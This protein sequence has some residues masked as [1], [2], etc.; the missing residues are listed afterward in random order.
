[1]SERRRRSRWWIL[2]GIAV[3]VLLLVAF[4]IALSTREVAPPSVDDALARLGRDT[5]PGSTVAGPAR[6]QPGLYTASG[7]GTEK[8]SL[9]PNAQRQ[10]PVLPV[11]VSADGEA[12]RVVRIDYTAN[13]WQ[14]WRYCTGP[15]ATVV[16]TGGQVFQ[17]IDLVVLT[18]ESTS[19]FVCDPP[20]VILRADA[21]PGDVVD[22]RCTGTST[23]TTGTVTSSGPATFVGTEDL[24]VGGAPVSARHLRQ[25]RTLSGAQ[26]GEEVVDTWFAPD[27]LPVRNERRIAVRTPSPVGEVEYIEQ[28]RW[29]LETLEPR[30]A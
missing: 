8:L 25:V 14:S 10:G 23:G 3:V 9:A 13:H 18:P 16:D 6:A 15:D 4:V 19:T 1:M 17:R 7:T 5:A 21:R 30:T 11:A 22:Q 20:A 28:G 2:A 26:S 24:T 29:T 12:C 27:G